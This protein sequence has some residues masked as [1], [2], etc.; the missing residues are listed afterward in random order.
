ME[1]SIED[2]QRRF[3][4]RRSTR[5]NG[6]GRPGIVDVAAIAEVS[7]GTASDALNGKGR[8][9]QATRAR[10]RAVA[11]AL[12]YYPS[13]LGRSLQRNRLGMIGLAIRTFGG[14]PL[15]FLTVSYYTRFLNAATVA[16]QERGFALVALPPGEAE[17]LDDVPLDGAI[18]TDPPPNDPLA[19]ELHARGIPFVSDLRQVDDPTALCVGNDQAKA[20]SKVCEHFFSQ[21]TR[22]IGI[23]VADSAEDYT[24]RSLEG[25]DAWIAAHPQVVGCVSRT[26]ILDSD[27]I[28]AAV[29]QLLSQDLHAV[30]TTEAPVGSYVVRAVQRHQRFAPEKKILV[31]YCA[32]FATD[33]HME[34]VTRLSLHADEI[35]QEAVDLLATVL[36]GRVPEKPHRIIETSLHVRESSVANQPE[37][38]AQRQRTP[39][40]KK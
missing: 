26:N 29:A 1:D 19:K 5:G 31:A 2:T 4:E 10:V 30:Y 17:V 15:Q 24:L 9:N 40:K 18:L 21:G 13:A 34:N 22:R 14:D 25:F 11:S 37:L 20:V 36:E 28:E 35:A 8:M 23:L 7:V 39:S 32:E 6:R 12:G 16:A 38:P 3:E 27:S 33:S